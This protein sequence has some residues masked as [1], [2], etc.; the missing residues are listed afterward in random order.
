MWRHGGPGLAL[1]APTADEEESTTDS[2]LLK[3]LPVKVG[4]SDAPVT[5]Y[6][7]RKPSHALTSSLCEARTAAHTFCCYIHARGTRLR[8][9]A[10][11]DGYD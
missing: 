4:A 6:E 2:V 5:A 7:V 9:G 1:Q 11:S 8:A 10:P 3:W